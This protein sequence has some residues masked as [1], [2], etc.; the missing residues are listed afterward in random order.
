MRGSAEGIGWPYAPYS[1][2][3]DEAGKP[4]EKMVS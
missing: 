1:Q 3:Q 2:K 4:A